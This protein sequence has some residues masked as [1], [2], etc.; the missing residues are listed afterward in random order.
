[1]RP[2]TTCF[3]LDGYCVKDC[4]PGYYEEQKKLNGMIDH[5]VC[6]MCHDLC[7]T[8]SGRGIIWLSC[9]FVAKCY[10]KLLGIGTWKAT[11]VDV[12]YSLWMLQFYN[13][14][15]FVEELL[16]CARCMHN[17]LRQSKLLDIG[18]SQCN[19][20]KNIVDYGWTNEFIG[21]TTCDICLFSMQEAYPQIV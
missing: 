21:W 1:M 15:N 3:I 4:Q 18:L 11:T 14:N 12:Y 19:E 20:W 16:H 2:I 13:Q 17:C 9:Y 6:Q 5:T 10:V 8:C 7:A